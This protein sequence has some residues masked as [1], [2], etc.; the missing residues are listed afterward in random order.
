MDFVGMNMRKD[1]WLCQHM[2][3]PPSSGSRGYSSSGGPAGPGLLAF[4]SRHWW[5]RASF[6]GTQDPSGSQSPEMTPE[7]ASR[8]CYSAEPCYKTSLVAGKGTCGKPWPP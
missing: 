8:S 6:S 3:K 4:M 5:R 1:G 2:G 7:I